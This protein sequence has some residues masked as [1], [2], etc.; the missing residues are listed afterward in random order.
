MYFS[1]RL[2]MVQ[3]PRSTKLTMPDVRLSDGNIKRPDASFGIRPRALPNPPPSWLKF[4]PDRGPYP[5]VIVEVEVDSE[6]LETLQD[7]CHRYF[8]NTTSVC[9]WI[10]IKVWAES[11][12]FWVAWAERSAN[13][14]SAVIHSNIRIYS[15]DTPVDLIHHIPMQTVYGN[16]IPI[17]PNSPD[18]LEIDH[19]EIRSLIQ[20]YL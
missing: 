18:T 20:E 11:R 13:G 19:D 15:I 12:K 10:G 7:D 6:G 2:I 8:S 14:D 16:G 9:I 17:P 5:N 1:V 4:L 3:L